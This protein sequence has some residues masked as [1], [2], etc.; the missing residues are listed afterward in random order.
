MIHRTNIEYDLF[1]LEVEA[2]V[3]EEIGVP[4]SR[5]PDNPSNATEV[6]GHFIAINEVVLCMGEGRLDIT[7]V[8]RKDKA[9]SESIK[10]EITKGL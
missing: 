8:A 6:I 7:E 4:E 5:H 10:E 1:H 3:V 2:N 9:I